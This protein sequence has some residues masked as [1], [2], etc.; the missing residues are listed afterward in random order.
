MTLFEKA[1]L[2]PEDAE[3][4]DSMPLVPT[5]NGPTRICPRAQTNNGC[6]SPHCPLVHVNCP[7]SAISYKFRYWAYDAGHDGWIGEK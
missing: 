2:R 4:L 1:G 5:A 7:S 3:L 6:N